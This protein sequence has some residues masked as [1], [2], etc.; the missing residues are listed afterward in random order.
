MPSHIEIF[1]DRAEIVTARRQRFVIDLE[2]VDKVKGKSWHLRDNTSGYVAT[3]HQNLSLHRFLLDAPVGT[4]VDHIDG[5]P[6]NNRRANLRLCLRADNSKNQ[7]KRSDNTSGFK[8]VSWH[9]QKRRWHAQIKING[10]NNHIG[11]F[12]T[13]AEAS[14]AYQEAAG[15]LFGEF[16]RAPEHE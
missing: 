12:E 16:K 6:K 2:D 10:K 3:G 14:L 4:E 8:G 9:K 11:Y 13:T 1:E 15:F 7:R 5:D